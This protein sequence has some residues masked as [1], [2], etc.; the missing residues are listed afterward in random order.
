MLQEEEGITVKA[1]H[2]LPFLMF[3][4]V[5]LFPP[6]GAKVIYVDANATG[7]SDGTSWANACTTVT[8]G[9]AA[10]ASGDQIWVKSASYHEAIVMVTG[11]ALYGGFPVDGSPTGS[12]VL[13]F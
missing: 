1:F 2:C 7:D 11:V 13:I 5:S 8:A 9:L 3:C 10:S 4:L 6:A 12:Q